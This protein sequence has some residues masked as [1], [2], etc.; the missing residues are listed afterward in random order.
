MQFFFTIQNLL[1]KRKKTTSIKID[2]RNW[3]YPYYKEIIM[4]KDNLQIVTPIETK[5]INIEDISGS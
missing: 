4:T 1:N 3:V 2:K 5:N